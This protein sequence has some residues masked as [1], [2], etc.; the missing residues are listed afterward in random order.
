MNNSDTCHHVSLPVYDEDGEFKLNE[1]LDCLKLEG[2]IFRLVH[3]PGLVEGLAAGD[4]FSL[5]KA[6]P[7]YKVVRRGGNLCL[8]FFTKLAT[9]ERDR[10]RAAPELVKDVERLGGYLDGGTR[11]SLIFTIPI[12]AGFESVEGAFEAAKARHPGSIWS[13]GNVYDPIDGV[14]PLNWWLPPSTQPFQ[15]RS[16]RAPA[17]R[18]AVETCGSSLVPVQPLGT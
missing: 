4:E 5:C 11:R 6:K 16:P 12:S 18:R 17:S 3:S 1:E 13:Y 14:T 15:G 7:G 8:W 9:I 10:E 2:G